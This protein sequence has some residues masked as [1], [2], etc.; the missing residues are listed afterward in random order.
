M[1]GRCL[2]FEI[3][4]LL[5]GYFLRIFNREPRS[6]ERF[7]FPATKWYPIFYFLS[8]Y[9]PKNYWAAKIAWQSSKL[10]LNKLLPFHKIRK[11]ADCQNMKLIWSETII[12]SCNFSVKL[13]FAY[14]CR[15][16]SCKNIT[17]FHLIIKVNSC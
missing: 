3:Q 16:S 14:C 17:W 7:L 10:A 11:N 12:H 6:S 5:P 1:K 9:A 13:F 2:S 4:S 8:F 15:A